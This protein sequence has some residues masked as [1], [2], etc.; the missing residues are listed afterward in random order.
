MGG[1][2]SHLHPQGWE[3]K[4]KK[5]GSSFCWRLKEARGARTEAPEGRRCRPAGAGFSQVWQG[6]FPE[7]EGKLG[8]EQTSAAMRLTGTGR[9]KCLLRPP[10]LQAPSSTPC[11]CIREPDGR[12]AVC[13]QGRSPSTAQAEFRWMDVGLRDKCNANTHCRTCPHFC[14]SSGAFRWDKGSVSYFLGI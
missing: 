13:L 4:M 3:S 8:T 11:W 7:Q 9:C 6:W 12:G 5:L 14:I 10:A 2:G 1:T